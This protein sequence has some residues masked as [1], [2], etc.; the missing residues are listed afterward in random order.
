MNHIRIFL[1]KVD[2]KLDIKCTAWLAEFPLQNKQV[3]GPSGIRV[4]SVDS[5]D[6]EA[7]GA[8]IGE[9]EAA[10]EKFSDTRIDFVGPAIDIGFR[11]SGK[12]SSR[13]FIISL[14]LAYLISISNRRDDKDILKIHYEGRH[15]LKGVLG[16]VEYPI[17]WIDMSVEG[18]SDKTEDILYKREKLDWHDIEDFCKSFYEDVSN[19]SYRP[20]IITDPAFEYHTPPRNY[21]SPY[22]KVVDKYTSEVVPELIFKEA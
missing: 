6:M 19:P 16:G 12:S 14:D 9:Y 10:P 4:K 20:F 21:L 3:I 2:S 17:F 15:Y 13:K 7:V 1:K 5:S 22:S 11:L 8:L 18:S